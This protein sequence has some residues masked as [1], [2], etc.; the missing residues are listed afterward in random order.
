MKD[1]ES[2]EVSSSRSKLY[3]YKNLL[4]ISISFF[5]TFGV[6]LSEIGLQS[7]V[8]E[9]N[10]LGLASLSIVY[11]SFILSCLFSSTVISLI[12][13]RYTMIIGY[14]GMTFYTV[15]NFYPS[16]YTLVPGSIV[17]GCIFGP[18]WSSQAVHITSIA[19]QYAHDIGK[20]PEKIV[21]LFFGIYVFIFKMAYVPPN[22]I[23]SV[24]LLIGRSS[25]TS[26]IDDSEVCNNTDAAHIDPKYFYILLSIYLV[27]DLFA[28]LVLVIFVDRLKTETTFSSLSKVLHNNVKNPIINTLKLVWNWKVNVP[29]VMMLLDGYSISFILGVFSKVSCQIL[30]LL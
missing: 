14:C 4:G 29:F 19:R 7:S 23:S 2:P 8:N 17:V 16:W 20:K 24:V 10:A 1:G 15:A 21:F 25:N 6:Y 28:I 3:S 27:F 9:D 26:I 30:I 22:I 5:I 13:T 12:G 11:G 18:L